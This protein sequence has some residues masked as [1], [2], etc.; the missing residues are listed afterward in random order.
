MKLLRALFFISIP[1][2]FLVLGFRAGLLSNSSA[3][4]GLAYSQSNTDRLTIQAAN[5][6]Q[7]LNLLY[8]TVSDRSETGE[9]QSAWLVSYHVSTPDV[10]NFVP[11]F[12]MEKAGSVELN[13][14]IQNNF[15]IDETGSVSPHFV[16]TLQGLYMLTWDAY[17]ILEPQEIDQALSLF[18]EDQAGTSRI[19]NAQLA[20]RLD[21][22]P[23]AASSLSERANMIQQICAGLVN[24]TES[25]DLQTFADYII[26]HMVI[27]NS[28][29][30]VSPDLMRYLIMN[31][32][33]S[34][35]FPTLQQ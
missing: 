19:A 25:E 20:I 18:G 3:D 10:V 16:E 35:V 17:L 14:L 6:K 13:D 23:Q 1:A 7:Q 2:V 8:L 30:S 24:T 9:L 26:A 34:C 5:E 15:S 31:P 33:L 32:R 4:A 29:S 21:Q 11:L 22:N 28:D 27:S 12:P